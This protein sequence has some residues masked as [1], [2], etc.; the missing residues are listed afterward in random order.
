MPRR[1]SPGSSPI[2]EREFHAW[3]ARALPAGKKG[4]LPLGDDAAALVPPPGHVV[5]LT[6][7]AL[8]EG[9]HF[10]PDSPPAWIGRA[11]A[12][13]S[14]SDAA[15]KG[16]RPA[17]LLIALL[18]PVGTPRPWAQSVALGAD[19]MGRSFGAPLVGGDTKPSPTRSVVSTVIGWGRKGRLAPRAAARPGDVVV[20]TGTVGRGG[21]AAYRW[22][23]SDRSPS[24]RRRALRELL[25]VRPR[26]R[27]GVV[28]SRWAHAMLDTS[29]GIAD[30]SRLLAEA[31]QV[32]IVIAEGQVPVDP[33]LKALPSAA[34]ARAIVYGG[35]YELLAAL[36]PT[37]VAGAVAAVR[38]AG[39]HLTAI[40]WVE[41]GSGSWI[42]YGAS[43]DPAL[44]E[45]MPRGGWRPFESPGP[46]PRER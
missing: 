18:L 1:P 8:V 26:V 29:D 32:R 24:G 7:D 22:E 3:L 17:G 9:T 42:Q 13:V 46:P 37:R 6:T 36:P 12:S 2:H 11:A 4:L 34:R 30:A 14:L 39:G 41:R 40:G 35:D 45:E 5:V 38:A 44:R 25:D 27:E 33:G 21:L 15:A 19:R 31:S 23:T 28:L 10:Q 43:R 16:S 20:T